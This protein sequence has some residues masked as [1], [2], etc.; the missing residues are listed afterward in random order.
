MDLQA[1]DRAH[2]LGQT[3]EVLVLR[4]VTAS[5]IEEDILE[6]AQFK[7]DLDN[8]VIQAG[9]F[10]QVA[11]DEDRRDLLRQLLQKVDKDQK[12]SSR[13][14]NEIV[15]RSDQ[16]FAQFE[17]ID[18]DLAR[19]EFSQYGEQRGVCPLTCRGTNN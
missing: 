17:R 13:D 12:L 19:A 3:K 9:L 6:R 15:A 18:A 16:E 5:T 7:L 2:R 14:I 8:K 11:T 1:Q 10:N 4:L